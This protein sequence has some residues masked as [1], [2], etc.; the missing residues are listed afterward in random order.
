[1]QGSE[2]QLEGSSSVLWCEVVEG[3]HRLPEGASGKSNAQLMVN[4]VQQ[5]CS[6]IQTLT[7]SLEEL[8]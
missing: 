1:M 3:D 8:P 7:V 2:P 4:T 5:A 6:E